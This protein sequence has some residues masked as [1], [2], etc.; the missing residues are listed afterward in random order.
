MSAKNNQTSE[1]K[2]NH[3]TNT[4]TVRQQLSENTFFPL[5][6]SDTKQTVQKHMLPPVFSSAQYISL[7]LRVKKT[8]MAPSTQLSMRD[9]ETTR[10]TA[11]MHSLGRNTPRGVLTKNCQPVWSVTVFPS[12]MIISLNLE[13]SFD[14]QKKLEWCWLQCNVITSLTCLK[15]DARSSVK[16]QNASHIF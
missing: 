7:G 6:K 12:A 8:L 10:S 3:H 5:P 9:A 16:L 1:W 4:R 14:H 11:E 2:Y 13:N 15:Q